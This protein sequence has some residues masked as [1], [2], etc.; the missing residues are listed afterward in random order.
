[1]SVGLFFATNKTAIG[2][3]RPSLLKPKDQTATAQTTLQQRALNT[4]T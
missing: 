3:H 2:P 4:L 1:M